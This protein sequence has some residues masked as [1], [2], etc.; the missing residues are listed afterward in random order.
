MDPRQLEPPDE[1]QRLIR[2]ALLHLYDTT[3][4][5]TH[6]LATWVGPIAP[7]PTASG[8]L[9]CQAL[10]GAVSALHPGPGA[11]S[12][13][14]GLRSYRILEQRYVVGQDVARVMSDVA[15]SKRQYHR[16]H[17]R[18]LLAVASFLWESW[19][20]DGRWHP[21]S[22][23]P[24][25]DEADDQD[26]TRLEAEHLSANEA[27]ELIDPA[28]VLRGV[29]DLLRP[30]YG[31]RKLE[32]RLEIGEAAPP[33]RGDRVALRQALLA[34]LGQLIGA[35]DSET[36]GL[37]IVHHD[38]R[39]ELAIVGNSR[40]PADA[41]ALG[42]AESR[43]FVESLRGTLT[44]RQSEEPASSWEIRLS[45]PRIDQPVLLVVDNNPDFLSLVQR[46]L[47]DQDWE[48]LGASD[49]A[50]AYDL[51]LL[52]RPRAILLDVVMP[53]QDGW[54]LLSRLRAVAGLQ[55]IPVIICS[56]LHEARIAS[57]L[58]AGYLKKPIT[59]HQLVEAINPYR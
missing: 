56:V 55:D 29:C 3:Y 34:I 57:A 39:H 24:I 23:P 45:F 25:P 17:G 10:M 11:A 28:E 22:I 36:I 33:I 47:V 52:R 9:L 46:Y 26:L 51:A 48:V 27:T 50:S 6:P 44:Y 4:L 30:A 13:S 1:F 40:V 20:L 2:D 35:A 41:L 14:T 18:A 31:D 16:E 19:G 8:K 49:A 37:T 7:S 12:D 43:P 42:I 58:G 15:L 59:Q 32:L 5:Q 21:T 38:G 53:G 54:E